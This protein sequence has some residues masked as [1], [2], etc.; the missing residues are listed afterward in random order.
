[1]RVGILGTGD[2]GQAHARTFSSIPGVEIAAVV[3]RDS[4]RT[5]QVASQFGTRGLTDPWALL[6]DDAVDAIDVTYPSGLHRQWTVAA[7]ERNKHVLCETPMALTLEDADAMIAAS[8]RYAKILMP[9]Q[10][11][12]FG[13]EAAFIHRE[14]TSGKM[15]RPLSAYAS[16]RSPAY[17]AG[18]TRSLDLHGGPMLDLMIHPIDT[19]NWFLGMPVKVAGSGRVGRSG[20]IECA[21]VALDYGTSCGMAEGSALMP[22]GYPFCIEIRVTCEDGAMDALLRLGPTEEIQL[23]RYPARG[24]PEPIELEGEDPY[25]GECRYFVDAVRRDVDP[26]VVSPEGERDA[27]AVALAAERAIQQGEVTRLGTA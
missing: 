26:S 3:G 2:M 11:Q 10:V 24:E 7:L 19:L 13:V 1:M 27:L 12:R 20:A 18:T 5:Q 23:V 14:V 22:D 15:G 21:F 17:G 4:A 8:R 6:D 9:A 16:S 25:T